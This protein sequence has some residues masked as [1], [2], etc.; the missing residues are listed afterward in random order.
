M[1][2]SL[3]PSAISTGA[4]W[5]VPV[6][7]RS[8]KGLSLESGT[9]AIVNVHV[10]FHVIKKFLQALLVGAGN[11]LFYRT[12]LQG[13]RLPGECSRAFSQ[14]LMLLGT[15][16]MLAQYFPALTETDTGKLP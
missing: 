8:H 3:P 7:R 16:V 15:L 12:A 6:R 13:A 2:F 9:V 5:Q 1:V 11:N 4:V 14:T 10:G